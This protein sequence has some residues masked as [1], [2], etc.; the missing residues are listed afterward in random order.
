[1]LLFMQSK[2]DTI[3]EKQDSTLQDLKKEMNTIINALY[4]DLAS[5]AFAMDPY[6]VPVH[7][8]AKPE[9]ENP[10]NLFQR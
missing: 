8:V 7:G 6:R 10:V 2:V 4:E 5:Y 3:K 1:M 9:F